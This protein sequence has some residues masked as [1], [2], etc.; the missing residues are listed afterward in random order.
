MNTLY[1][2]ENLQISKSF[3]EI[4]NYFSNEAMNQ[5]LHDVE[6]HLFKSL[7][8]LGGI[9]LNSFLVQKGNGEKDFLV[10]ASGEKLPLH[11]V[12]ERKYLSIFGDIKI[13]RAY[14][15]KSG[16]QG[17]FPLDAE[18]NLPAQEYSYLLNKWIQ[19]RV[20]EEPYQQAIES[21]CDLLDLKV[22]KRTVQQITSNAS[23]E[24]ENFYIQKR[25]FEDEGS[26]LVAQV[27]CKGVIMIPKERSEVASKEE[28]IRRAKGVSKKGIRR[29][30]VVTADFSIDPISRTP[31]ELLEGLMLINS[32][33]KKEKTEAKMKKTR[34]LK[35]KQVAATMFGKEKA[36]KDLADRLES[37]DPQGKKPIFILIDG[38]P[39]LEKGFKKEFQKRGWKSRVQGYCLDI[40]H[41]TEYLWD[42]STALYGETSPQR[43]YWVR[44]ALLK[45]LNSKVK[46]VLRELNKKIISGTLS[47]FVVRR[48]TRTITYFENHKHMMDYK[49]YL[50]EGYPIASGAIEGACNTLVKDRTDRSGMQWTKRGAGSVIN[51]RSVKCNKDWNEYWDYYIEKQAQKL[52]GEEE[53]LVA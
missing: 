33:R 29:D 27:D 53:K 38:A 44:S 51:L 26:H 49:R 32:D 36:F 15:W 31:E 37:R 48:L 28:S 3:E 16:E 21:I 20:T 12:K 47:D 17:I 39:S 8:K 46:T 13:S 6:S 2:T 35:N 18:L 41:A 19:S 50:K 11:S 45:V 42:A 52:Y 22:A 1:H 4:A 5:S 34:N 9:L 24:V 7:L 23:Q 43:I 25:N 10:N 40:V 14:F 30:A